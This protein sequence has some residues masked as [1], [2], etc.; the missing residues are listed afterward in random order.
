MQEINV[1]FKD[2]LDK[3]E[4]KP[5]EEKIEK[6]PVVESTSPSTV[7]VRREASVQKIKETA[8]SKTDKLLFEAIK[9]SNKQ[10]RVLAESINNNN[11]LFLT[12]IDKLITANANLL[13]TNNQIVQKLDEMQA[14]EIPAPIVQVQAAQTTYREIVRDNKGRAIGIVDTP[15]E[16]NE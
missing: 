8:P 12:A 7:V 16:D 5:V 15:V 14:F 13:E 1:D 2:Y 10:N 3:M 9:T 6:A 11:K 4:N